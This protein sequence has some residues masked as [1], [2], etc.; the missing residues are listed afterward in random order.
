MRGLLGGVG[1]RAP[2]VRGE[3]QDQGARRCPM[4]TRQMPGFEG[5]AV[6]CT[7]RPR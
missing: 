7:E 5:E 4:G 3:S 2:W 1:R 6:L